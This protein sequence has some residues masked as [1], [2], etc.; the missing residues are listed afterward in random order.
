LFF[1]YTHL[2]RNRF[3]LHVPPPQRLTVTA[4]LSEVMVG[5]RRRTAASLSSTSQ[6]PHST[7]QVLQRRTVMILERVNLEE[8]NAILGTTTD[9]HASTALNAMTLPS[10]PPHSEV[11]PPPPPSLQA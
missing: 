8:D 10:P 6:A 1:C 7:I 3:Q 9:T 2:R 11:V 4:P 5:T